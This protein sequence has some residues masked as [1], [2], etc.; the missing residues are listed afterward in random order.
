[1]LG[2]INS[3][4]ILLILIS[5]QILAFFAII[6]LISDII[7]IPFELHNTFKIEEKYRFQ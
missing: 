6:S 2:S 5:T 1:M 3:L 4:E 7:G